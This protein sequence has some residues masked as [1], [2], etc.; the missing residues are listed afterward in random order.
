WLTGA[1]AHSS[2]RL[3][4]F[5]L[6]RRGEPFCLVPR[7]E[8]SPLAAE[9]PWLE[10]EIWDEH[11]D[12]FARLARRVDLER[13]PAVLVSDG[14]K[15]ATLLRRAS[16][17]ACRP[18]GL[19]LEPLRAIKDADELALLTTAGEHADRVVE[20]TADWMRP[21]MTEKSVARHILNAFEELGDTDP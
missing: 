14:L 16:A 8:A 18:A 21:G 6:P 1:K 2:E 4:L 13:R 10:L 20:G 7:L 17:T 11:E 9:C 19:A 15:A 5:A 3:L 12:A